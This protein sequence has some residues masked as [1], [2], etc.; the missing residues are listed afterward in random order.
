M[1]VHKLPSRKKTK[2]RESQQVHFQHVWDSG[3]RNKTSE[4]S[5]HALSEIAR[6]R[7]AEQNVGNLK[8]KRTFKN[9]GP[10][11]RRTTRR[12]SQKL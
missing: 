4:I 11:V 9:S 1:H 5:K 3:S 6:L 2:R 10:P 8:K 12:K 7:L